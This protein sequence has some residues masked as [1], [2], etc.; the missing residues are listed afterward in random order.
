[1]MSQAVLPDTTLAMI[2]RD[3]RENP[4][5][6]IER[7]LNFALP[8]V[9]AAVIVD[10]GSIDGTWEILQRY[11]EKCPY[12]R[13]FQ[14]EWDG[15]APS[16]NFS[17]SQV[18]TRK[19]LVMDADEWL[20]HEDYDV[21]AQF[22]SNNPGRGYWFTFHEVYPDGTQLHTILNSINP[23]I[24]DVEGIK[25]RPGP[26]FGMWEDISSEFFEDESALYAPVE[27]KHFRPSKSALQLK[28]QNWYEKGEFLTMSPLEAA[29]RDG[30]KQENGG[31]YVL[32]NRRVSHK[33][34]PYTAFPANRTL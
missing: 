21:M 28:K 5:G 3:E 7:F 14:R 31:I 20:D 25:F 23:R 6:G 2:V 16:R 12:L 32:T 24:F 15:F 30:W 10:T 33:P 9:E 26:T 11:A 8:H 17:L 13:L 18:K 27:I 22:M 34:I 29:K 19:A 1:M 4:A